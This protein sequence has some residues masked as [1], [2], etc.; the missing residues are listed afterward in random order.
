M[1]AAMY[2]PVASLHPDEETVLR[3]MRQRRGMAIWRCKD[4]S[5]QAALPYGRTWRALVRLQRR[6][7]AHQDLLRRWWVAWDR[8]ALPHR[9]QVIVEPADE[10]PWVQPARWERVLDWVLRHFGGELLPR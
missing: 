6:G 10:E 2:G 1:M 8:V 4:V 5:D 7:Y 9:A 3:V